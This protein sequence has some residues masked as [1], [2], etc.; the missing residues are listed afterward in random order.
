MTMNNYMTIDILVADDGMELQCWMSTEDVW[1]NEQ[2]KYPFQYTYLGERCAWT[3]HTNYQLT[4][5][6][7]SVAGETADRICSE[8][9][10]IN[11]RR[12]KAVA[13]ASS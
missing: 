1:K 9:A 3:I 10:A 13:D 12:K 11:D 5:K 8:Q 6:I 4:S 2:L 7:L